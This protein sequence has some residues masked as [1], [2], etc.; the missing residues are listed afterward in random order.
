M[1]GAYPL[2]AGPITSL[3]VSPLEGT[4][5]ATAGEDRVGIKYL[6]FFGSLYNVLFLEI[7]YEKLQFFCTGQKKRCE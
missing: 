6:L 5:M 3:R 7:F 2:H 1:V 4:L